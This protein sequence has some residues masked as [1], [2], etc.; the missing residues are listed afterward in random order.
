MVI[1]KF[2]CDNDADVILTMKAN[3]ESEITYVDLTQRDNR[4]APHVDIYILRDFHANH[5]DQQESNKDSMMKKAEEIYSSIF[6]TIYPAK[7]RK[8]SSW[9]TSK[10]WLTSMEED[11]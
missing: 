3:F 8:F 7:D 1:K 10:D 5:S 6:S 4:K 9:K 2:R 11:I